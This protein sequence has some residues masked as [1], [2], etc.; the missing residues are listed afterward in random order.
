MVPR[1]RS[2]RQIL[3]IQD[4]GREVFIQR[5]EERVGTQCFFRDRG[6]HFLV[7]VGTWVVVGKVWLLTGQGCAETKG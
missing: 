5:L 3:W 7:S 1:R 4:L 2:A 6:K